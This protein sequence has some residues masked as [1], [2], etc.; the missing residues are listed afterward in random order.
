MC[1]ACFESDNG[2]RMEIGGCI[3][4]AGISC[5][6]ERIKNLL[7]VLMQSVQRV[8]IWLEAGHSRT[9]NYYII[10]IMIGNNH[11]KLIENTGSRR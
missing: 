6:L 8:I 4:K 11:F 9:D 7:H 3:E 5:N 10:F 1:C 2:L